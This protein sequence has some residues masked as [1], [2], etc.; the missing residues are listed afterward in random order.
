MS[1]GTFAAFSKNHLNTWKSTFM[2]VVQLVEGHNFH[3]DRHF[4]FWVEK[5]EKLSQRI[6]PPIHWIWVAFKV[7]KP[8]VQNLLRKTPYGLC[9]SCRGREIYNFR[10]QRFV[11]LCWRIKYVSLNDPQAYGPHTFFTTGFPRFLSIRGA[12]GLQAFNLLLITSY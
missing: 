11:H 5:G 4:K 3:V 1:S 12:R 6:V 7:G 9:E 2:E 10:I 8:C